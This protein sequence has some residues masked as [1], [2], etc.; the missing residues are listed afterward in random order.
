MKKL[1][2]LLEKRLNA[3]IYLINI[4]RNLNKFNDEK[5]HKTTHFQS[6]RKP[7]FENVVNDTYYILFFI[8]ILKN[9]KENYF[10]V[11]VFLR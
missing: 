2:E 7:K 6:Y 8:Q 3:I 11:L 10:H 4:K 5:K 1:K 9:L